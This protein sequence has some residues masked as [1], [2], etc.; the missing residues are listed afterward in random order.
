MV[1]SLEKIIEGDGKSYP[2]RGQIVSV[3]YVG[4]LSDG[5][6]FDNTRKRGKP[7]KFR[8]Q[9]HEVIKGWD[10]GVAQMSLGERA[11]ITMTP[12]AAYGPKG[13]PGLIPAATTIVFDVE[14]LGFS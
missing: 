5:T 13:F 12:D 4:M 1:V 8:L 10:D 7:F 9:S 3:H 6:E 14:L 2:K 11:K